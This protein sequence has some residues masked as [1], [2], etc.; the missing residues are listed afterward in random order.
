MK[1]GTGADTKS[2]SD[3]QRQQAD[4]SMMFRLNSINMVEWQDGQN[5]VRVAT[6]ECKQVGIQTGAEVLAASRLLA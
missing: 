4:D 2:S 5:Y 6:L 1:K 3:Y